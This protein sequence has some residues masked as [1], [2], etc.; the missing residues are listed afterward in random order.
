MLILALETTADVCSIAIRD[1]KGVVAE[2]A[3]RHRMHLSERLID[4]VDSV[5]KDA[6]VTLDDV[7]GFGVGIGPGS[8]TGVRIG[9]TTVK[10]WAYVQ[11]KPVVGVSSLDA[12][13]AEYSACAGTVIAPIVRARPG[14]V[15]AAFYEADGV[16]VSLVTPVELMAIEDLIDK[17]AQR[18]GAP[19]IVCGE[20]LD[21]YG[22]AIRETNLRRVTPGR[23]EAPRASV[24]AKIAVARITAGQ[25]DDSLALVPLYVSPPPI[26]PPSERKRAGLL[27]G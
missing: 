12:L 3:F 25:V 26:G 27:P 10:T 2:R 9:V 6:E 4:D 22:D 21:R 18:A 17:L 16:M 20:A 15:Y 5:L 14:T 7:E 23:A 19:I 24:V 1:D 8:F 13:A 11:R